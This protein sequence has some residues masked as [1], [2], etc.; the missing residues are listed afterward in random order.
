MR[1]FSV[2]I[3]LLFAW[4][5]FGQIKTY[6]F[7]EIEELN[8]KTPKP[9]FVFVHTSWCK[10]CKM[11]ENS[12]FKNQEVIQLLNDSFYFVT[13]DAEE[14]SDITFLNHTFKFKPSGNNTGVHELAA[15]L[16]TI[17]KEIIYPTIVVLAND[18]SVLFQKHSFINAKDL[19]TILQKLK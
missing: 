15:E 9:T 3:L 2:I 12:T 16:S 5:S 14:Q 18:F 1:N 17:N 6:S 13:L 7:P 10:Y 19:K 4:T 11:M 8:K